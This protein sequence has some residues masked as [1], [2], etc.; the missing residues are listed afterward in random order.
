MVD[1][2]STVTGL[3]NKPFLTAIRESPAYNVRN[4]WSWF[5]NNVRKVAL[6][7]AMTPQRFMADNRTQLVTTFKPGQMLMFAYDA[8]H[9]AALPYWDRYPLI[10]P[11]SVQRQ[12]VTALNLHYLH[13]RLRL[14]LLDKLLPYMNSH[15][16]TDKSR[17]LISWKLLS[18]FSKFPQ[19]APCVKMYLRNHMRSRFLLIDPLD[20]TSAIFLPLEKFGNVRPEEVWGDSRQVINTRNKYNIKTGKIK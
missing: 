12:H 10:F 3:P 20:W 2:V 13:P 1:N 8:K 4:S 18:N 16:L 5:Q 7:H 11:F 17:L 9:K 14:I 15:T 6:S 19:V